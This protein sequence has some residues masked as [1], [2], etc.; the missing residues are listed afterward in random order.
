MPIDRSFDVALR[1]PPCTVADF[2]DATST[3]W[4]VVKLQQAFIPMDVQTILIIPL[5]NRRQGD[6]WAWHYDCRGIFSV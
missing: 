2:I 6:F 3:T 4:D 1:D 5:G